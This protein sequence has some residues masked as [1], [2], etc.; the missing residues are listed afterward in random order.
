MHRDAPPEF[1][2]A[3]VPCL[4]QRPEQPGRERLLV[5]HFRRQPI[6]A[7]IG[8]S[9]PA[10]SVARRADSRAATASLSPSTCCLLAHPITPLWP[11]G[12][13]R[14]GAGSDLTSRQFVD[15][16]AVAVQ[17]VRYIARL[18]Q[19]R[20]ADRHW[21]NI[22]TPTAVSG[23]P[24]LRPTGFHPPAGAPSPRLSPA[25]AGAT[26]QPGCG[27]CRPSGR[28]PRPTAPHGR[29]GVQVQIKPLRQRLAVE[30]QRRS[31]APQ[32]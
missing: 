20:R 12:P 15:P 23:W 30:Q 4:V 5:L 31:P 10:P 9:D 2:S 11:P 28:L 21:D 17:P 27:Q 13:P 14:G 1:G 29:A 26:A 32:L 3:V 18:G 25:A 6:T 19:R 24:D 22:V 7:H 8:G 16:V